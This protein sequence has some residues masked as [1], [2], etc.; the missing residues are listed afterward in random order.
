MISKQGR[1][2]RKSEE[3]PYA[4][5]DEQC[6]DTTLDLALLLP[7]MCHGFDFFSDPSI[8]VLI[9]HGFDFSL[10]PSIYVVKC[11]TY[12]TSF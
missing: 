2:P 10:D 7:K 8:Y 1:P 6:E 3:E 12:L 9:C 11:A 4:V 5:V